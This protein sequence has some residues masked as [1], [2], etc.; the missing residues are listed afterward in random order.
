MLGK[1]PNIRPLAARYITGNRVYRRGL[2]KEVVIKVP[3]RPGDK[4][5]KPEKPSLLASSAGKRVKG[6][7]SCSSSKVCH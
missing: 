6:I 5:G 4:R 7:S 3:R 1:Q 2:Q